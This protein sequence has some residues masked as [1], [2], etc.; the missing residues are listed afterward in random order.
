MEVGAS[1]RE[2]IGI[3][4]PHLPFYVFTLLR[5]CT[6]YDSQG[7]RRETGGCHEICKTNPIFAVLGPGTGVRRK[8]EPN[9]RCAE[10]RNPNIEM[11][12]NP[13]WGL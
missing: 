7:N 12:N 1:T 8:N 3:P 2:G 9:C 11:R 10:I 4:G 6:R 13:S 5:I